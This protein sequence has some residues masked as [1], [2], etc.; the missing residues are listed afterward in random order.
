F[1][2]GDLV[3]AHNDGSSKPR[4]QSVKKVTDK[5]AAIG[6]VWK[7]YADATTKVKAIIVSTRGDFAR[8]LRGTNGLD[9]DQTLADD[10]DLFLGTGEDA[11]ALWS[12][13]DASNH[14]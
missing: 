2:A 13:A 4:S 5:D 9:T 11:A 10:V 6:M 7:T 12:T 1:V 14:T 3:G 8:R